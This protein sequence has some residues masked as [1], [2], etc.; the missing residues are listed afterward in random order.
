MTSTIPRFS[1]DVRRRYPDLA[2][3]FDDCESDIDDYERR[4]EERFLPARQV[5]ERMSPRDAA[6]L[7][8]LAGHARARLLT[9]GVVAAINADIAATMFLGARA[10]LETAGMMA[11]NLWQSRKFLA[12]ALTLDAIREVLQRLFLGRRVGTDYD[13]PHGMLADEKAVQV[14]SLID[15]V[16]KI[17]DADTLRDTRGKFREAYEWLSEFCHPNLQSRIS[18]HVVDGSAIVFL[19]DPGIAE[20]DIRMTLTH[21]RLSDFVVS[22]AFDDTTT[23][24]A[25]WPA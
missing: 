14:L 2:K 4:F 6:R 5:G 7:N 25:S 24:L 20:G 15:S 10:H 19:R 18:D 23:L 17:L 9:R 12:G 1:S 22:L 21:L 16:D 13:P 11:Y 3:A 8:M